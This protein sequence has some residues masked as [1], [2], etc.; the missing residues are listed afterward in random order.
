MIPN[1]AVDRVFSLVVQH[2]PVILENLSELVGNCERVS[3]IVHGQE[4][5]VP[6][7]STHLS[8]STLEE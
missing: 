6:K 5:I 1:P 4:T 3:W 2:I 8:K 7:I